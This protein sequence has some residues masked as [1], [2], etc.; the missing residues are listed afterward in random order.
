LPKDIPEDL[1]I[2]MLKNA[3]N[4]IGVLNSKATGEVI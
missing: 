4:P 2:T 3:K 1:R